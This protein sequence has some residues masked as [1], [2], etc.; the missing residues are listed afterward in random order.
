MADRSKPTFGSDYEDFPDEIREIVQSTAAM[1]YTADTNLSDDIIEYDRTSWYLRERESGVWTPRRITN[2]GVSDRT[3]KTAA[4]SSA[5]DAVLLSGGNY[6]YVTGADGTKG[7]K[8]ENPATEPWI[9]YVYN[10]S[11]SALKVYIDPVLVLNDVTDPS[12]LIPPLGLV[13]CLPFYGGGAWSWRISPMNYGLYD[14]SWQWVDEAWSYSSAADAGYT[15]LDQKYTITI[16]SG[17]T[18]RFNVGDKVRLTHSSTVK[19]FYIIA[20]TSTTV[21]LYA[22]KDYTLSNSAITNISISRRENPV[23]FPDCFNYTEQCGGYGNP[24][25]S[26]YRFTLKGKTCRV[27]VH[28]DAAAATTST[29]AT[30]NVPITSANTTNLK[31]GCALYQAVDNNTTLTT[32]ARGLLDA[33]SFS[34]NLYT[35]MSGAVWTNSGLRRVSFNLEYQIP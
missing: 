27:H 15:G 21:V 17:G 9:K 18:S 32:A 23:G 12:I 13:M 34:I 5:S 35:N 19:Y 1:D 20:V 30:V 6:F 11:S 14:D 26:F 31:W 16:P 10:N 24:S 2:F 25:N 29:S 7:A 33:N 3:P 4:G 28:Q 22:G 8:L